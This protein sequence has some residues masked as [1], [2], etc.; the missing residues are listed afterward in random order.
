VRFKLLTCSEYEYYLLECDAMQSGRKVLI[1]MFVVELKR[2]TAGIS[3]TLCTVLSTNSFK[4]SHPTRF[5]IEMLTIQPGMTP[6]LNCLYGL[7]V[8]VPGYRCR[9][10][11]FDSW[12]YQIF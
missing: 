6:F 1:I 5:A 4:S 7:V 8:R 11:G 9:C 2:E 3:E 10:P 12:R